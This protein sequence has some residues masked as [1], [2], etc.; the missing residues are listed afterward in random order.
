MRVLLINPNTST[1]ITAR[2]AASA[3][4][5]LEQGDALTA[6]TARDGPQVVRTAAQL[7]AAEHSALA[8]AAAHAGEHDAIVLAISLDGAVRRLRERHPSLA[9]VGMTEAALLTAC[10]RAERIGLLT[11]GAGL[12]PLYR[13]RV[14]EIGLAGR[15]VAYAAP[16]AAEAFGAEAPLVAPA[17]LE[18]LAEAC[19]RLREAGA[20]TVVLAGAVLCGYAQA[21]EARAGLPVLDGVACALRLAR[22]LAAGT[23]RA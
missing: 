16:E 9:V 18:V 21:L 22:A 6:L 14:A 15:V 13:E 20:Q 5:A 19:A 8:L 17:V 7:G 4:S 12:L 11:L 23:P 1:H 2:L 3:R 10:L